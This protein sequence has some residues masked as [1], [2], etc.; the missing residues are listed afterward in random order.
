MAQDSFGPFGLLEK[1]LPTPSPSPSLF[2]NM[3]NYEFLMAVWFFSI[4]TL[5]LLKNIIPTKNTIYKSVQNNTK[6]FHKI[7]KIVYIT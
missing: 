1:L 6:E 5:Y 3:S 4:Q 2:V 7:Q